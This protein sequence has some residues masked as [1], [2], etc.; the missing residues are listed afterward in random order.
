MESIIVMVS[1]IV[2]LKILTTFDSLFVMGIKIWGE[3][4]L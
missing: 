1:D 3:K 2:I 4:G